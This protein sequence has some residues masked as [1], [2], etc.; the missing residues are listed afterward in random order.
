M[1]KA[2]A[3][4]LLLL[5]F[6]FAVRIEAVGVVHLNEGRWGRAPIDASGNTFRTELAVAPLRGAFEADRRKRAA[7]W[8]TSRPSTCRRGQSPHA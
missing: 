2:P 3:I 6:L 1:E 5:I 8:S 4:H 7:D